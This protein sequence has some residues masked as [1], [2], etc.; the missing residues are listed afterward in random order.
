MSELAIIIPAYR[1][2]FL[3]KAL[4]SA[5]NQAGNNFKVYVFDDCSNEPIEPIVQD[6]VQ[7]D[8]NRVSYERFDSNLGSIKLTKHYDRC[9]K[10]TTEPWIWLFSDDDVMDDGSVEAFSKIAR[11][12][13]CQYD[14]YYFNSMGIDGTDRVSTLHPSLPDQESWKQYAYF[15]FRGSRQVPQQA[16]I[17]SRAAYEKLGGFVEFPVGWASDQASLMAMAGEKG[18]KLISGPKVQFRHSGENISST[19]NSAISSQ[20]L[21]AAMQFMRWVI[22]Q[23]NEVPV[24]N[25]PIS[26]ELLRQVALQWFKQHLAALHTWYSLGECFQTA[27]FVSDTWGEPYWKALAFILRLNLRLTLNGLRTRLMGMY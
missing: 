10:R 20:K 25:F 23:F 8:R 6:A 15:L 12:T 5:M 1:A 14:V 16:M 21:Q 4:A 22:R 11:E 2:R 3:A 18:I 9:V 27:R 26:D 17:F 24:Q 19:E 7:R 13:G